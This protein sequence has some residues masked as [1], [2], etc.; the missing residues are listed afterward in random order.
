MWPYEWLEGTVVQSCSVLYWVKVGITIGSCL[1]E[2][3]HFLDAN[4]NGSSLQFKLSRIVSAAM[5]RFNNDNLLR[6]K[7]NHCLPNLGV[8]A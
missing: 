3:N 8:L 1:K 7:R 5:L 2:Y 4:D 6:G